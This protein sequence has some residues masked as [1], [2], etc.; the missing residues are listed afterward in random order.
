MNQVIA[1]VFFDKLSYTYN[2]LRLELIS[3]VFFFY[4][5]FGVFQRIFGVF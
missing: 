3:L 1:S 5:S 2:L 4:Y